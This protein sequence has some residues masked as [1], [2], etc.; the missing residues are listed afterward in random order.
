[1]SL[2]QKKEFENQEFKKESCGG[3]D[4]KHRAFSHV[5]FEHCDFSQ[6]DFSSSKFLDCRLSNCNLSLTKISGSRLQEVEFE[7]CK[8][9]G[10]DFTQC[11]PMFLAI[12]FNKCL[13]GTCNFSGLDLKNGVFRECTIR[14]THFK[15]SNLTGADF[16]KSDLAG[17]VFH[18]ANLSQANFLGAINYSINPLTNKLSKAKFSKPEVLS[19][20][21][22]MDI[23]VE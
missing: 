1:M 21:D 20:L 14:D 5:T 10:V 8:L 23:V 18:N 2:L 4:L 7:S 16:A 22:H 6:A 15:E 13:I 12:R 3:F 19:L 17:T 9:V 11:N